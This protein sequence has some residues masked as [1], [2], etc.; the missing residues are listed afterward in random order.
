M[1]KRI[2]AVGTALVTILLAASSP[3]WAAPQLQIR[4]VITYPESNTTVGGTVE[5]RGIATHLSSQWWYNVSY[6]PGPEPTGESQ[7]V[8]LAQVDNTPVENDV[9]VVWDTTTVP[10]GMYTL[11]LTIKAQDDPN[12]WQF[13]V[14]NLSVNNTSFVATPTPEPSTPIPMPTA[15]VGPTS[16]PIAIEQPATPT[17]RPSPMPRGES[18]GEP[19]APSPAEEEDRFGVPLDVAELRT[20][21]CTGGL[22]TVVLLLLWGLYLLAKAGVRWF[23]RH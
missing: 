16:T 9:L 13:F 14:T 17:P 10:D 2:L 12:Y 23:L 20:A 11:A 22:V 18:A 5:I 8:T 7:W 19:M 15:V 3:G 4:S 6:A 1:H 21:F